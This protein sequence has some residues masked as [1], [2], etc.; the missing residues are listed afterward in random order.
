VR[1]RFTDAVGNYLAPLGRLTDFS[2]RP[3]E[4]VGG[5]LHLGG[6]NYAYIDGTC[7]IRLPAGPVLVEIHKG[8]EYRPVRQEVTPGIGKMALR[9]Q[10]ERW[11]DLR[12]EGWYAGDIRAYALSPHAALLEAAAEDLAVGN[13]LASEF[14]LIT[15]EVS[16]PGVQI[17]VKAVGFEIPPESLGPQRYRVIPNI[18]AF[19]G[20][21]PALQ[22]PGH[23]VV[24]NTQNSHPVLG[25]L[26]L[27]NCHRPVY[28]L[29]FG[30]P[31]GWD[32]WTLADWC[33]QCHRKGGLVV[34]TRELWRS[35]SGFSHYG[36]PL[37]DLVL[38][39]V[40]AI[41][42]GAHGWKEAHWHE[43]LNG[44]LR[45]PVVGGSAKHSNLEALG[46]WRT[47]ACLLPG[48]EFTYRNWI[49]AIRAGRTFITNG[50]L[51]TLT[52]DGKEPGATVAVSAAAP[53]VRVRTEARS[54][55]P[56]AQVQIL[57]NGA[58]VAESDAVEATQAASVEADV[59][60]PAGGWVAARCWGH[61]SAA[62]VAPYAHTSPVY[63]RVTGRPPWADPAALSVLL[64]D[65]E[66]MRTWVQQEA[67][68]ETDKQRQDLLDIFTSARQE[69]L[70]RQG[71]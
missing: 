24:V 57:A 12:R 52:A 21:Q 27:L 46:K 8:P 59:A 23:L 22:V 38:G 4:D 17:E 26:A 41:E 16:L 11:I 14:R 7:E 5:N 66:G 68:C 29:T 42:C 10:V 63:V 50:P 35:G 58:V 6:R 43:L 67:R 19:S 71:T 47:Y 13:L 34:W 9:L 56:F 28:P 64:N 36:E 2:T 62:G 65:L 31:D 54:A 33:D 15:T 51:L 1:L 70:R 39:K 45:L 37:A 69:L 48:E 25:S 30:G 44:G 53:T 3:F 20:Q 32:D 40:D 18:L 60:L 55:E 61:R 49:E